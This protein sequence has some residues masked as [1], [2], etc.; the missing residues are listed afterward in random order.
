MPSARRGGT[1]SGNST[2]EALFDL[3]GERFHGFFSNGNPLTTGEFRV[4]FVK[5]REDFQASALALF[6]QRQRFL[7]GLFFAR[8]PAALDGLL[9]EGSLIGRQLHVH[10][11]IVTLPC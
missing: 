10:K 3:F 9:D 11:G 8:K 6:P 7:N 1:L 2:T 5:H 4:S